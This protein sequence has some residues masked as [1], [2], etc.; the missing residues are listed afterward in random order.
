MNEKAVIVSKGLMPLVKPYLGKKEYG[1]V[2]IVPAIDN[3][4]EYPHFGSDE[5][6]VFFVRYTRIGGSSSGIIASFENSYFSWPAVIDAEKGVEGRE[7]TDDP[8]VV[9]DHFRKRLECIKAERRKELGL[10]ARYK[11][12]KGLT[13][14]QALEELNEWI[15]KE[16]FG[17]DR[18]SVV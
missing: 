9:L 1:D 18:K 10:M 11:I 15:M 7:R 5:N 16:P 13:L 17:P 2:G 12:K 4:E 6:P 3:V 14:D 8:Y